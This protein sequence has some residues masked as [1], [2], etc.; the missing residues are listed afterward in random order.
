MSVPPIE[1]ILVVTPEIEQ[2]LGKTVDQIRHMTIR[3]LADAAYEKGFQWHVSMDG[4]LVKGLTIC[5]KREDQAV[6]CR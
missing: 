1:E 4:G 2:L 5:V 3:D 6:S